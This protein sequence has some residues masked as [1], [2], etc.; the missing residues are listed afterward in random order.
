MLWLLLCMVKEPSVGYKRGL[1]FRVLL[2]SVRI[3]RGTEPGTM[4]TDV[5]GNCLCC[6]R[7][8]QPRYYFCKEHGPVR[9]TLWSLCQVSS[10]LPRGVPGTSNVII[11]LT[12]ATT[13][14]ACGPSLGHES[15]IPAHREHSSILAPL[16]SQGIPV[17]M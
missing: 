3:G 14:E 1:G 9:E 15:Y 7:E 17:L 8:S 5:S 10:E 4:A 11:H 2:Q 12:L 13:S 6:L 16:K